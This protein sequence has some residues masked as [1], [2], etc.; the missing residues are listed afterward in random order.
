[1]DHVTYNPLKLFSG[2]RAMNKRLKE[3]KVEGNFVGEGKVTGGLIIFG[4]DGAPKYMA[5]E[6]TGSP[7]D[8]EALLTALD[9]VREISS[10]KEE[11]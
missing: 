7:L 8:E 1:M 4:A 10:T 9:M 5:P 3:K 11:S 2:I 6:A